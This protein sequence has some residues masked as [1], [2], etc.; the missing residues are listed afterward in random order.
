[1]RNKA[2]TLKTDITR[3]KLFSLLTFHAGRVIKVNILIGMAA[4]RRKS[5]S[6]MLN[7]GHTKM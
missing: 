3:L 7:E 2:E 5:A 1:M 4:T 6:V